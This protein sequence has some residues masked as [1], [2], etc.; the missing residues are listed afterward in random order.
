MT[1]EPYLAVENIY[2]AA[3][4][5]RQRITCSPQVGIVLGSGLS[6]LAEEVQAATIIP[7]GEIPHFP[8]SSVKGHAGRLVIG[9]LEGQPVLVMQGRI[10]FYEGL[11]MHQ[12]VLPIRVMQALGIKTLIVTNAAGGLNPGFQQGDVMLITDHINLVGM[13]GQHPLRGPND[14]RL[15]PRFPDM[16][17][18]YSPELQTVARQVADREGFPLREGVYVYLSG[19]SFETPAEIRFLRIIGADAVGMSTV[20][21]VTAARHAGMQVIA[22]SGITN[23]AISQ[24][25]SGKETTHLEVLET[26]K[27]IAPRMMALIK[28]VLSQLRPA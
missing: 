10:H 22:A 18:V 3:D 2:A 5:V 27:I 26:G 23:I 7:Y 25:N 4:F 12:L 8:V 11:S 28:G 16:A 6:P 9:Y 14:E 19:P 20:P 17:Q 15:G 21:E 24:S 13:A 1:Q